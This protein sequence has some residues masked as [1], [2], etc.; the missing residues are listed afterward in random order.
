MPIYLY[1]CTECHHEFE[2]FHKM[3]EGSE[4]IACPECGTTNPKKLAAPFKTKAWS[5][6]LDDMERK[7]SPQ[8]FK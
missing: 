7:V 5:Q 6:F 2:A 4:D 3:D 8:K 1:E